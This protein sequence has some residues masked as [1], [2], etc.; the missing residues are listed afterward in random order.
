MTSFKAS[1]KKAFVNEAHWKP[2]PSDL[3]SI[4]LADCDPFVEG[5]EEDNSEESPEARWKPF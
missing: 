5:V 3:F 4:L 1:Y 2:A